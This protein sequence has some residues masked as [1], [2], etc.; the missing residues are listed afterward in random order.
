[1]TN[2]VPKYFAPPEGNVA[3]VVPAVHQQVK[4]GGI[5]RVRLRTIQVQTILMHETAKQVGAWDFARNIDRP[6][7]PGSSNDVTILGR[8]L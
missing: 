2:P 8:N 4:F 6:Y 3:A 1:M 5:L 7:C